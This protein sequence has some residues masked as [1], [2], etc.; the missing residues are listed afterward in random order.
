MKK[1]AIIILVLISIIITD[2]FVTYTPKG[3]ENGIYSLEKVRLGDYDQYILIRGESADNPIILFLHGGPGYPQIGYVRKYQKL[4]EE[5]FL[6]V[7]W[8]QLGSG[9]SYSLGIDESNMNRDYFI[10]N[11]VQLIEYLLEEYEKETLFLV[12]HSWGSNLG[13]HI[14][15]E[16]SHL[17]NG[18]LGVGQVV[19]SVLQEQI[20]YNYAYDRAKEDNNQKAINDLEKIGFPP[21]EN[22]EKDVMIQRKWLNYY[23]GVEIN[24]NTLRD[25]FTGVIFYPEYSIIDGIRFIKGNYLT[26]RTMFNS[27]KDYNMIESYAEFIIPIY[28]VAGRHD[29]NTPSSLV[30]DYFNIIK[31][32]HKE[33]FWFEESAHDPHF[34]EVE[35]FYDILLEITSK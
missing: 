7:N 2:A 18:Y 10:Q 17:L 35:K 23:D 11:T 9:K 8:D 21:Y 26:R 27:T 3:K 14:A 12:G 6:V 4:L 32:P 31:A 15:S 22:H 1:T 19:D 33:F 20:S 30:K 24:I 29:F 28:F 13:V 34:E 16:Y 25:L 5:N